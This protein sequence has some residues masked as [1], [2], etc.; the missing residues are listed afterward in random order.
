L[1]KFVFTILNLL[2]ELCNSQGKLSMEAKVEQ[3]VAIL[4][5]GGTSS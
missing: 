2:E 5:M 1:R 4:L 3:L